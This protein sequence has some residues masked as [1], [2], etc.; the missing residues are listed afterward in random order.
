M[1]DKR[2]YLPAADRRRALLDA[3]GR[4]FGR[5]GFS[6]M[7]MVALAAEAGVSRP[8]VY[9]YFPDQESLYL[10]YFDDR[11]G[12]YIDAIDAIHAL[13]RTPIETV[14]AAYDHL[15]EI[16]PDDLMAVNALTAASPIPELSAPHERF[17]QRAFDRWMPTLP[18]AHRDRAE[19]RE[20]LWILVG[21]TTSLA[22]SARHG[23]LTP[24]EGRRVLTAIVIGTVQS[25]GTFLDTDAGDTRPAPA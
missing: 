4:L 20:A 13:G 18:A 10:A 1:N 6:A 23:R 21:A 9:K 15:L 24:D 17:R 5:G 16:D 8:L 3:A 19:T 14:R 12:R 7:T 11:A 25:L 2:S 22:A